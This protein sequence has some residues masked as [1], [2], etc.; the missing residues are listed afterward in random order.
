MVPVLPAVGLAG[1]FQCDLILGDF[2]AF[3]D[4]RSLG[5]R[6][7][8]GFGGWLRDLA[9]IDRVCGVD[10]SDHDGLLRGRIGMVSTGL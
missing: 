1:T 3:A 2:A 7:G 6:I 5:V 8:L 10:W 9:G 4:G